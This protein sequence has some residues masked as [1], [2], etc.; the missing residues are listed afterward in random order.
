MG[1]E[2]DAKSHGITQRD[3]LGSAKAVGRRT[4]DENQ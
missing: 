4:K 2:I 3:L 1:D